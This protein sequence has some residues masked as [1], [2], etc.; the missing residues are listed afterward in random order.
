MTPGELGLSISIVAERPETLELMRRHAD[1][2][3]SQLQ[4]EGFTDLDLAFG[5]DS[6]G[7]ATAERQD[8]PLEADQ[9][10]PQAGRYDAPI[11]PNAVL[12]DGRSIDLRV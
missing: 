11:R 1:L 8:P 9:P 5:R 10:A 2:L 4:S 3:A 6:S 12:T 7:G